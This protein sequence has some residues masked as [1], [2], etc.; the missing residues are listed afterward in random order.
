LQY[1]F[2]EPLNDYRRK[3]L[4]AFLYGNGASLL[5]TLDLFKACAPHFNLADKS[6]ITNLFTVWNQ[7]QTS[8]VNNRFHN[9]TIN[10]IRDLDGGKIN[11]V[12]H[13][14][15]AVLWKKDFDGLTEEQI[16]TILSV[17]RSWD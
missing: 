8:R 2:C 9:L 3:I 5:R 11:T 10:E 14:P 4:S 12:S 13:T 1:L 16:D 17:F 7:S 6:A 15:I